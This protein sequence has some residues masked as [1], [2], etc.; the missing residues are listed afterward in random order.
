MSKEE[1]I[2]RYLI[3]ARVK[4]ALTARVVSLVVTSLVGWVITGNPLI[5]LSIGAVDLI[6]KLFLYYGHETI[7]E[8]KMTKDI[9]QIKLEYSE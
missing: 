8:K 6:I 7:W 2:K 3:W 9:K 1:K 4:R 5:G